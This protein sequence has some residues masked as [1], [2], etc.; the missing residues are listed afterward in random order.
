MNTAQK[1]GACRSALSIAA[2]AFAAVVW[3]A[4]SQAGNA[5]KQTAELYQFSHANS[6]VAGIPIL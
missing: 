5:N 4:P 1:A 6:P 2:A 3:S